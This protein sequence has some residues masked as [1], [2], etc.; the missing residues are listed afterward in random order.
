MHES[1]S[2]ASRYAGGG[3]I[4]GCARKGKTRGKVI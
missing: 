4:D 1:T 2:A 3:S